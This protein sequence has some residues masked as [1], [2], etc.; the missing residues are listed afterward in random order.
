MPLYDKL[1]LSKDDLQGMSASLKNQIPARR[2][3]N[4]SENAQAIIFS[5]LGRG[6]FTVGSELVIDGGLNDL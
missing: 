1:G 5:R 2:F 3:G 6:G 4:P